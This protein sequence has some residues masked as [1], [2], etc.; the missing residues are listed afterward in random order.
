[1]TRNE[2]TTMVESVGVPSTYYLFEDKTEQS[3]P[4]LCYYTEESAHFVADGVVYIK[5]ETLVLELYT[6]EK[7]FE[8]EALV[9]AALTANDLAYQRDETYIESE[10][11]WVTTY[12]TEVF[13]DE[14]E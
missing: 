8:L 11:L 1:M 10:E 5:I 12:T 9:E 4:Y 2:I 13:I 3:A 6:K 14:S 7:N